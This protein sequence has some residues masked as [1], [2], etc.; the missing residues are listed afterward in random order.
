[1]TDAA[2]RAQGRRAAILIASACVFVMMQ[3]IALGAGY[4]IE[5]GHVRNVD[6]AQLIAP[7]LVAVGIARGLF[8]MPLWLRDPYVRLAINDERVL[9]N[10]R[11]AV[12]AGILSAAA[13]AIAIA[14]ISPFSTLRDFEVAHAAL[15]VLVVIPVARFVWLERKDARD[16][17]NAEE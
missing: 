10:R 17:R 14:L 7:M 8:G 3:A 16:A 4:R 2:D 1:M 9:D 6:I 11:R 13:V 12:E 5:A 15:F